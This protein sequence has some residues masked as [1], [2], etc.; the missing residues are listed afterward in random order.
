MKKLLEGKRAG[1]YVTL[2]LIALS[3]L[4]AAVYALT[5]RASSYMSWR[6]FGAIVAGAVL[7]LALG[8]TNLAN[9]SNAV[10]ALG[11]FIGLL[12]YAYA[13]YFYVSSVMVGIQGSRFSPQFIF[14][15]AGLAVLFLA[16]LVNV[17]LGQVK[18]AE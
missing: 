2:V 7:A 13:S 6:A 12:L 8:F 14:V 11:D 10:V 9:W 4:L 1:F 15:T 18:E 5:F 17:F 16:N 3:L